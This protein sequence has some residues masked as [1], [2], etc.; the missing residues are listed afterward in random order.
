MTTSE[1]PGWDRAERPPGVGRAFIEVA[2]HQLAERAD[3]IGHCV[4]QLDDAQVWW[5]P[6][7][8]MNSV[9][10]VLLHLCGNLRQW[11]VSGVGGVPDVR[12]RPAE[13]SERGAIPRDELL[14]RFRATVAE[15]DGVLA[16]LDDARLLEPRRVQGFDETVLSAT[17]HSLE[18]LGGHAQE[19]IY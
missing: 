19:I 5:R 15:V 6:H 9:A 1:R 8:S 2:R 18:H 13:F 11:I 3:R 12:D 7:E 17:W 4:G 14:G 16:N 10:N